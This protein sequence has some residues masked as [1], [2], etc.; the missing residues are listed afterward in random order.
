MV[1][2]YAF[3]DWYRQ[4]WLLIVCWIAPPVAVSAGQHSVWQSLYGPKSVALGTAGALTAVV[5]AFSEGIRLQSFLAV[6]VSPLLSMQCP[7][8]G[9]TG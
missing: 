4:F 5:A 1:E 9:S 3:A 8:P 7:G 2:G 6:D